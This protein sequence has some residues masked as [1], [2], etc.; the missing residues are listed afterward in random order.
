[1]PLYAEDDFGGMA[2]VLKDKRSHYNKYFECL[3]I[4]PEHK[5]LE[6]KV[7]Y[8]KAKRNEN[9]FLNSSEN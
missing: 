4:G 3:A 2:Q 1:M 6:L 8:L 9:L 5:D 7:C